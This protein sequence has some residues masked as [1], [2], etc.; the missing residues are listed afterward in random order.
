MQQSNLQIYISL[1]ACYYPNIN[2]N[3]TTMRT[4][5][6]SLGEVK[7]PK[8][9]Y[10]GSFTVRANNNFQISGISA[11]ITFKNALATLKM[12]AAKAN[13]ELKIITKKQEK[14]I[15]QACKELIEGKFD[16]QFTLDVFQAGAGTSYN[17]NSNEIIANRANE[18][19]GGKKGK[20]E[21]VHPNNHVNQAQSTNDTIPTSTRIAALSKLQALTEQIQHL[22]NELDKKAKEEKN[23]LKVGRT[24]LM[25]AV[26]IT[27][28]KEFD[29]YKQALSKSRKFIEN[30]AKDL[31]ILGIG[32]TALGTGINT[33]PNFRKSIVKHL[34]KLTGQ[35]FSS[36]K[37]LTEPTNNMN[38]FMNFS[39]ALRSLATNLLNLSGDLKLM[40][41]GPK[42]GLSE[43]ELPPVQPGSSIMPGKINPSIPECMEMICFQVFGND[44]T[45]EMSAQRS[46]FDL[47]VMCPII[48]FNLLQSM[49]ILTNGMKMLRTL[50]I[51]GMKINHKHINHIFENS[52]CTATALA[53]YIGYLETSDVVKTALKKGITI[54]EEVVLRKLLPTKKL[55][56]ILSVKSTTQPKK[57]KT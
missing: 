46:Q 8:N 24:H 27:M 29:A 17:M 40:N 33:D 57:I 3:K 4:E 44:K 48:M 28:G 14:A 53:P 22:E 39:G 30:Q 12:A 34:S 21:Y 15:T 6:D 49:E 45:I 43:I 9:A 20:Y 2:N 7:V 56:E 32:G 38:S 41:M 25:D 1:Q 35:N 55:D 52:L 36:A 19:L 26:P 13:G 10:F 18:L 23:T 42:A 11:P 47:N 37:N 5:K 31:R 51:K 50:A 54:K 16:N